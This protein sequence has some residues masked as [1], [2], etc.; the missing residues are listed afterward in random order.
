M[1]ERHDTPPEGPTCEDSKGPESWEDAKA[2]G[3]DRPPFNLRP[4]DFPEADEESD[5]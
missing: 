3:L 2:R 5:D 4:E 1:T